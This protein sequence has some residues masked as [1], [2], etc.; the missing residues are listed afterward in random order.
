M[1][2]RDRVYAGLVFTPLSLDYLRSAGM[3]PSDPAHSELIYEL[4]FRP[5]ESPGTARSEPIMLAS[6][7]PDAVNA[8]FGV[9]GRALVDRINGVRIERLEDVIRAFER[10]QQPFEVFEFVPHQ[11]VECL[12]RSGLAEANEGILKKYGIAQDRRL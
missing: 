3:D 4:R 10:N 9:R 8:N 5:Q 6:V 1:C 12:Q 11:T 2:I 7:L